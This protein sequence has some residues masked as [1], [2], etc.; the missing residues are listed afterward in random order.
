VSEMNSCVHCNGRRLDWT[1]K[2][3]RESQDNDEDVR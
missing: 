1:G 2:R 3:E